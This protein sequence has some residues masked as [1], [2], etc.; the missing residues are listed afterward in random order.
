M[1]IFKITEAAAWRAAQESG[2]FHGSADDH[3]DGFIH[4]STAEQ[5]MGTLRR[6]YRHRADLLLVAFESSS[7]GD[8][9]RWEVSRGGELFPHL[10]APLAVADARWLRALTLRPDGVPQLPEGIV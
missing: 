5:L 8:L 4:F 6:H 1:L 10:Y 3:R 9:L 7:F 2:T